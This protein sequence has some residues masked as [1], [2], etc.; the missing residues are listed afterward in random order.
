MM[1]QRSRPTTARLLR[2]RGTART[3]ANPHRPC[4]PGMPRTPKRPGTALAKGA[5]AVIYGEP[6]TP[7]FLA[8]VQR[9]KRHKQ[10]QQRQTRLACQRLRAALRKLRLC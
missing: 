8:A 9:I 3:G 6:E 2:A 7:R 1:E 4:C 10:K 5:I